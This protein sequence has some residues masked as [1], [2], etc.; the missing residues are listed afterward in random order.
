MMQLYTTLKNDSIIL[1]ALD[2]KGMI[3]LQERFV[4][5]SLMSLLSC[6]LQLQLS[7]ANLG[8]EV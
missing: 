6:R 8:S 4:L 7:A 1:S 5:R 3:R 2:D